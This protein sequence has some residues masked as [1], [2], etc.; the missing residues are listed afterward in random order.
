MRT[1]AV[2]ETNPLV[3]SLP[4]RIQLL[5]K[6]SQVVVVVEVTERNQI[7]EED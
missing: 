4:A 6:V 1:A 5:G 7:L 2:E 3:S